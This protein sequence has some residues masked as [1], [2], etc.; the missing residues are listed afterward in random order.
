MP[1][2]PPAFRAVRADVA[3]IARCRKSRGERREIGLASLERRATKLSVLALSRARVR[4]E[5]VVELNNTCYYDLSRHGQGGDDSCGS[6]Q[7]GR[8]ASAE[9]ACT[10]AHRRQRLLL[11]SSG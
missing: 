9:A 5:G 6:F 10:A 7:Y 1:V 4:D 2:A 11:G 8:A 3:D